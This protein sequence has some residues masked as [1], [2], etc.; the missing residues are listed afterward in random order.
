MRKKLRWICSSDVDDNSE[1]EKWM[2]EGKNN[3]K[4]H[5]PFFKVDFKYGHASETALN[6]SFWSLPSFGKQFKHYV[7]VTMK[8]NQ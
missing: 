5:L 3:K 2:Y 6:R 7:L 1:L 4:E 8:K